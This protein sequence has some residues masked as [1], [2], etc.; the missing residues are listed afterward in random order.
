[1]FAAPAKANTGAQR[2]RVQ[3]AG[4]FQVVCLC[5]LG[6]CFKELTAL[7]FPHSAVGPQS[8]RWKSS[9]FHHLQWNSAL[10]NPFFLGDW[11]HHNCQGAF[12]F[13]RGQQAMTAASPSNPSPCR[14][15]SHD[16]ALLTPCSGYI[17]TSHKTKTQLRFVSARDVLIHWDGIIPGLFTHLEAFALEILSSLREDSC[18][19]DSWLKVRFLIPE[20][21]C[22]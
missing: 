3:I 22:P 17:N 21:K 7:K 15:Q 11:R 8:E 5:S 13:L 20:E 4:L 14:G 10:K 18:Q 12:F 16:K 1:M 9:L 2:E 19:N 6:L